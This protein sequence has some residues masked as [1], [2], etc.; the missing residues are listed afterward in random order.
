[1]KLEIESMLTVCT[2]HIT[3]DDMQQLTDPESSSTI[4]VLDYEY[5]CMIRVPTKVNRK[6]FS[7]AFQNLIKF[8]RQHKCKWL[9]LDCDGDTIEGLQT[10][11]W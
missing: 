11:D 10:F 9:R 8:V 2:S 4:Y 1:M 6:I 7:V 5:G 3:V